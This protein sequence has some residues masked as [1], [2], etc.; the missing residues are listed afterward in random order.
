VIYQS[1]LAALITASKLGVL[2]PYEYACRFKETSPEHLKP[3]AS[4]LAAPADLKVGPLEGEGKKLFRK[5]FQTMDERRL[6]AAHLVY[7]PDHSYW[8]V[9]YLDQRDLDSGRNHWEHGPHV[10]Y[11]N[12]TFH[13]GDLEEIWKRVTEGDTAFLKP[14]H[15]RFHP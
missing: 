11:A 15:I 2:H 3:K 5:L 7:T 4:E 13:R 1:D 6:F 14:L 8:H 10:H 12:D 9:L